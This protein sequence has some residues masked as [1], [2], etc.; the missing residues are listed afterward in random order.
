MTR[1]CVAELRGV[2]SFLEEAQAVEGPAPFTPAVLRHFAEL[3]HCGEAAFFEVDHQRRILHDRI[4]CSKAAWRGMR[5]DV[6]SCTRTVVF[7]RCKIASG[8]GPVLLSEVFSRRLRLREDFNPNLRDAG[9]VDEI[10]VDLDPSRAWKAEL[11]VYGSRDFG[12]RERA[13]LELVRPHLAAL[14]RSASLR[15][16]LAAAA[17]TFDPDAATG[18]L[19]PRE[20]EV[21]LCVADGLSNDQIANVLVIELST[22]RKHLEHVYEKLGVRSRTAALAKVRGNAHRTAP[23]KE[24]GAG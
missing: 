6:W 5:D 15:R 18:E 22:V 23:E 8:P 4:T 19:T 11:A 20:R 3:V 12:R 14:Y 10:H 17:A 1:L 7:Q 16:R 2:L 13:I 21:L 24:P 9:W